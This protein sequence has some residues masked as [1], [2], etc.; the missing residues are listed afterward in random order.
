VKT[1]N[2][3]SHAMFPNYMALCTFCGMSQYI[4]FLKV[5]QWKTS[6]W[7]WGTKTHMPAKMQSRLEN[8][9]KNYVSSCNI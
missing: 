1:S 8:G 3:T 7:T 6:I 2:P 5:V 4:F 9:E